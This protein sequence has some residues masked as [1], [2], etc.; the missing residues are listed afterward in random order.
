MRDFGVDL[1]VNFRRRVFALVER[2][3]AKK[4]RP[5]IRR[6]GELQRVKPRESDRIV[7]PFG[8]HPDLAH[9]ADHRVGA[10]Q[11]R[12]FRHL[13]AANE[14]QL[15]LGGNKPAGDDFKHH[16]SGAE[17]QQVH[18]KHCATASKRFA[19]QSLIA[20]RAAQEKAVKRTENPAKQTI[21]QPGREVFL[22]AVRL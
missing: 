8:I 2:F 13:H 3:Q 22:R 4:D 12:T 18:R 6:V 7:D 19:Y 16:P 9:F 21:D 5:G 15:I 1:R 14:I 17:Q 11:R 20:V 10:R